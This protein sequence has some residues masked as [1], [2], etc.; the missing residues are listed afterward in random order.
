M[1]RSQSQ[2]ELQASFPTENSQTQHTHRGVHTHGQNAQDAA[3][4]DTA[5]PTIIVRW[6]VNSTYMSQHLLKNLDCSLPRRPGSSGYIGSFP[7]IT[8]MPVSPP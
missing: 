8:H 4:A 7:G 5:F 6:A 3:E 1:D 2:V